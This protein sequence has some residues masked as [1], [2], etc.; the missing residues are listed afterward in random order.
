MQVS[1]NTVSRIPHVVNFFGNY[2]QKFFNVFST[3]VL[4]K[5]ENNLR[6]VVKKTRKKLPSGGD[7]PPAGR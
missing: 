3:T 1:N 7:Q 4:L 5:K 2:A 6:S